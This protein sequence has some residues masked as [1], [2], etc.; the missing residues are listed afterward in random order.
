M[1]APRVQWPVCQIGAI[2]VSQTGCPAHELILG[3]GVGPIEAARSSASI[4][5]CCA[6]DSSAARRMGG[7]I[8]FVLLVV[9]DGGSGWPICPAAIPPLCVRFGRTRRSGPYLWAATLRG[10]LHGW[11]ARSMWLQPCDHAPPLVR[12]ATKSLPEK[13]PHSMARP[14]LTYAAVTV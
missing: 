10:I 3:K 7:E 2:T 14:F 6:G 1:A 4:S 8:A 9:H 5:G 11:A 13:R 12:I